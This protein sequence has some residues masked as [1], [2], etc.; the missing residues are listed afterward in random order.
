MTGFVQEADIEGKLYHLSKGPDLEKL[1][2][3]IVSPLYP[4]QLT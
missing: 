3:S 1:G 2:L 4:E